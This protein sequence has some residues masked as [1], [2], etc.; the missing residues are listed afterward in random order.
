MK[1]TAIFTG[2]FL[3]TIVV[4]SAWGPQ[5]PQVLVSD[6]IW[7]TV[8]KLLHD[9]EDVHFH[10][11]LHDVMLRMSVVRDEQDDLFLMTRGV[12]FPTDVSAHRLAM[13][14]ARQ[15]VNSA[16]AS[17][18][19]NPARQ[20]HASRATDVQ[21]DI[22]PLDSY[23]FEILLYEPIRVSGRERKAQP[24]KP[25][26]ASSTRTDQSAGAIAQE[27]ALTAVS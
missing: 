24:E 8:G 5:T 16:L 26:D 1:R 25:F 7:Q 18:I 4:T 2:A 17:S 9:S 12:A 13:L 21:I 3:G 11:R 15:M 23:S 20:G 10:L 27:A 22:A 6:E 14:E 19:R